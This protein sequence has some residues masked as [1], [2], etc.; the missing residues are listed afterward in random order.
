VKK[1]LKA[2]SS[3]IARTM[4]GMIIGTKTRPSSRRERSRASPNASGVPMSTETSVAASATPSVA[5][6][7]SLISSFRTSSPYHF[8]EKPPHE[9]GRPDSL[10]DSPTSTAIG[11]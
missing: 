10:N 8:V 11:R 4:S 2:E 7:A 1:R 9:V 6:A 3:A 5:T